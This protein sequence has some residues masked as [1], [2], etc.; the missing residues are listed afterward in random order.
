MA[1]LSVVGKQAHSAYKSS[2]INPIE[3]LADITVNVSGFAELVGAYSGFIAVN[4]IPANAR[5]VFAVKK[6]EIDAFKQISEDNK[7][8][9]ELRI[10][11]KEVYAP[12]FIGSEAKLAINYRYSP[13]YNSESLEKEINNRLG[14]F[15]YKLKIFGIAESYVSSGNKLY[16][17]L[18][19]SVKQV[20]KIGL[21]KTY[22]GG[23]SDTRHIYNLG[24]SK[25]VV[26]FG[27]IGKTLHKANENIAIKD[28]EKLSKIYDTMLNDFFKPRLKVMRYIKDSIYLIAFI[29]LFSLGL[30]QLKGSNE[31][32][33]LTGYTM[34]TYYNV[35]IK[36]DMDDKQKQD[37]SEIIDNR[38][39]DINHVFS[40]FDDTS[41][42]RT[43]NDCGAKNPCPVSQ[44]FMKMILKSIEVSKGTNGAFDATV[45][46]LVNFWGFGYEKGNVKSFPTQSEID[47]IKE[48]VGYNYL[49]PSIADLTVSKEFSDLEVDFAAIAK[50]YGVDEISRLID[51]AGYKTHI[52]DI[53]GE[54]VAKGDKIWKVGVAAPEFDHS[55][56][57]TGKYGR[58]LPV[59]N[60][61]V[62]TSGDYR[63]F[64]EYDGKTYSHEI[65]PRTG[66][67]SNSD[68]ASVTVITDDCTTADAYATALMVMG[69][70]EGLNWANENNVKALFY[71]RVGEDTSVETLSNEMEKYLEKY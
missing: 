33:V 9:A 1:D 51:T 70:D 30:V 67:P 57:R 71:V 21:N 38:L 65:D 44:E 24:I 27:M 31:Y 34:G 55:S 61:A 48:H 7:G 25:D 39:E 50:G 10:E 19:N 60:M 49:Y 35:K 37:L 52:V 45:A 47:Y 4:I 20:C 17:I 3:I 12:L 8:K 53:G 68:L 62:A 15:D 23:T 13:L 16:R 43:F 58:L 54:V 5:A 64:F 66:Y 28:M 40:M 46:P 69:K 36:A 63:N 22:A 56:A 32:T 18:K 29:A 42:I 6:T 41:E 14:G 11:F 26:D 2:S 59:E